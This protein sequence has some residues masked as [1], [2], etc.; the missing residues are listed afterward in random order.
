M[1]IGTNLDPKEEEGGQHEYHHADASY[2]PPVAMIRG[3]RAH[4]HGSLVS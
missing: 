2:P 3:T 1:A 4:H